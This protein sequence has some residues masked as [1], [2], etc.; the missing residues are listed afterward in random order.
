MLRPNGPRRT[1]R[2]RV[3]CP[4][5]PSVCL[6][7]ETTLGCHS[8]SRSRSVTEAN[9]YLKGRATSTGISILITRPNLQCPYGRTPSAG[10]RPAV[11]HADLR[12]AFGCEALQRALSP[13]PRQGPDRPLGRLRPPHSDGV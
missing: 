9:T 1:S 13:Q 5:G 2:N 8:P 6:V 12:R 10:A 7:T 11:G 3:P 4:I